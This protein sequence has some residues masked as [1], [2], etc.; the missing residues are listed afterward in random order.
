MQ[1]RAIPPALAT[2]QAAVTAGVAGPAPVPTTPDLLAALARVPDPRRRQGTRFPLAAVLTL[3]VAALLCNHL[4]VLAIAEWAA[5][6]PPDLLPSLGLSH[7]STPH[8]S[9]LQRLFRKL[10]P[11][12]LSQVLS[13]CFVPPSPTVAP[14][15][16]GSQGIAID[17][18]AHRGR[19]AFAAGV[20]GCPVHMLSAVSHD[21]G[22]VLAQAP[23]TATGDKAQG[24][25]TVAPAL[26]AR[27]DWRGRVLTGDALFCQRKICEQVLKAGGD[28]LIIVKENQPT[29]Y[30]DLRMLFDPPYP[31]LLLTDRREAH[32]WDNGHGRH[33]EVRRL[34]A[35]TDLVGYSDWPG[36]VQAFRWER[37][38]REH[39]PKP[40]EVR[41]GITSLPPQYADAARL[42]A[43][44]RGHWCIENGLHYVKDVTMG[45]DRSLI[46]EQE[47]PNVIAMLRDAALNLLRWTGQ[48]AI[49]R[50]LRYHSSHPEVAVSLVR[51]QNA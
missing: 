44:K 17:G 1:F 47:G 34:V 46:H 2:L 48:Q 14:P 9:T 49:A 16:R 6:Q 40:P 35:S 37:Q 26:I 50:R 7:G 42:L 19:L 32:S 43:L 38:W 39:G 36:L 12:D 28:Y 20:A 33:E 18:K 24:E 4:S 11:A 41:Y 22:L 23:I 13:G 31:T 27:L 8:Q 5:A 25:L 29:L 10:D 51:G 3:A 21:D 30:D 45:E 15:P